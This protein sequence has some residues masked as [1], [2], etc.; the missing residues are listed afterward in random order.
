MFNPNVDVFGRD[1]HS[2]YRDDMGGVG[3]FTRQ[4]RTIYVGRIH[5]TDDIEEVV[6]RHFAEWGQVERVSLFQE[7]RKVHTNGGVVRVL[8]TR[9]SHLLHIR[10]R[11]TRSLQRR[12]W[13]TRH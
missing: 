2:D 4:N 13:H 5:V 1:K 8:N 11:Q 7:S 12:Q 9:V 10:T 6:A 3:S